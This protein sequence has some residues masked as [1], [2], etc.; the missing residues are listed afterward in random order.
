MSKK[1]KIL[2]SALVMALLLTAGITATVAAQEPEDP[3]PEAG[4][5]GLMA[6]VAEILEIDEEGLTAAFKQAREE[7]K[8]EA[9]SRRLE[10]A[11]EKGCITQEEAEEVE[12]WWGQ[13]PETLG[14]KL[15]Q[16]AHIFQAR[17]GKGMTAVPGGWDLS[18]T[19]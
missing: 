4:V 6:R 17:R 1:I 14:P 19:A 15:W 16:R 8:E 3:S 7:L 11:V 13:K 5:C 10:R 18:Q 2:I 9:F 12:D